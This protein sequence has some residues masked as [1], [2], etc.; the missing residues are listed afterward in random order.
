MS[1]EAV[2]FAWFT[3]E[4][5]HR[6]HMSMMERSALSFHKIVQIFIFCVDHQVPI[7]HSDLVENIKMLSEEKIA[8]Y[9]SSRFGF[10]IEFF[11]SLRNLW[12]MRSFKSSGQL[13][14]EYSEQFLLTP[15]MNVKDILAVVNQNKAQNPLKDQNP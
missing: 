4:I 13:C 10:V 6:V 1:N 9:R 12:S 11:S 8:Y 2:D 5:D 14:L 3:N 7:L 15:P